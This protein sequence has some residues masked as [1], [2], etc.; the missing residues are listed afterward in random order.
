MKVSSIEFLEN[1]SNRFKRWYYVADGPEALTGNKFIKIFSDN[2]QLETD[3]S[4]YLPGYIQIHRSA[5]VGETETSLLV[6][7]DITSKY[8][9]NFL[10][11]KRKATIRTISQI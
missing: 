7:K 2:Q 8:V 10:F 3:I 4:K 1:L 5:D 6:Y 9:L 11:C